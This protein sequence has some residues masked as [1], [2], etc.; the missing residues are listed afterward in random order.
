MPPRSDLTALQLRA[1]A[2]LILQ[3][4]AQGADLMHELRLK[5]GTVYPMLTQLA[6]RGLVLAEV[7]AFGTGRT[8]YSV[9]ELGKSTYERAA[10]EL[11]EALML[12]LSEVG[13]SSK[14]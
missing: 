9:T 13:Q 7:Q 12:G 1:L 5:S 10:N 8:L 4:R 14:I 6:E 3:P 11:I 2:L